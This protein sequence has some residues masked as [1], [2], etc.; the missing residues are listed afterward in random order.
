[1]VKFRGKAEEMWQALGSMGEE[2]LCNIVEKLWIDLPADKPTAW[3]RKT[4]W[5]TDIEI[6]ISE[7]THKKLTATIVVMKLEGTFK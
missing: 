3:N 2:G 4:T 7:E 1:M 5:K 6:D